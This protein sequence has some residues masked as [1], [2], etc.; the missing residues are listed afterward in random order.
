MKEFESPIEITFDV[1][2]IYKERLADVAS[3]RFRNRA[4]ERFHLVVNLRSRIFSR[5]VEVDLKLGPA[6][7]RTHRIPLEL[8]C[9]ETC[10]E[11]RGSSGRHP[12]QIMLLISEGDT[13]NDER[14]AFTG[15]KMTMVLEDDAS[16]R[17]IVNH[18]NVKI[19][20][21]G[22]K[23]GWGAINEI[24]MPAAE[25][26]DDPESNNDFLER[27]ST[28]PPAFEPIPLD[29][30]GVMDASRTAIPS[31]VDRSPSTP[32]LDRCAIDRPRSRSRIL[33]LTGRSI[34][35]GKRRKDVD[36][37][38]WHLPRTSSNDERTKRISGVQCRLEM[39]GEGI[40]LEHLSATN[41]TRLDD[42][43]VKQRTPIDLHG[44]SNLHL[45]GGFQ[46]E[47]IPQHVPATFAQHATA[48]RRLGDA[49]FQEACRWSERTHIG[50]LLIRR[51][52]ALRSVEEYLWVLSAIA[53]PRCGDDLPPFTLA[54]IE[55][56]HVF[57]IGSGNGAT[58]RNGDDDAPML[59][60]AAC[61]L[62][63][64]D[65]V[66]WDDGRLEFTAWRQ[67]GLD[68]D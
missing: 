29:Y 38:T 67:S 13:P 62:A 35:F 48:W 56:L 34:T 44:I 11:G 54:A 41:Q 66:A 32:T 18:I 51:T 31:I 47:L 17:T 64:D 55:G 36:V 28:L 37:T 12:I 25:I 42:V 14:H 10:S 23:A 57:A 22:D 43:S 30:E 65:S 58:I 60:N 3:F 27:L 39:T 6:Q 53:A 59:E 26:Q 40:C 50:G 52:D 8:P 45:P 46:L 61:R 16:P 33:A 4:D 9:R 63:I 1:S 20:Q 19:E 24:N 15:E 68:D 5:P 7:V 49:T 2:R 21:H